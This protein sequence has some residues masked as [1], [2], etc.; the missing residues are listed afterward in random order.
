[1]PE[2]QLSM[3]DVIRFIIVS[4]VTDFRRA[5]SDSVLLAEASNIIKFRIFQYV[6]AYRK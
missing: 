5:F 4:I 6:G 2:V 3:V 1:M